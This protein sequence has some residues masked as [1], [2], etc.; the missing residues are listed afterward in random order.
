LAGPARSTEARHRRGDR[1]RQ[2]PPRTS[3]LDPGPIAEG[4]ALSAASQAP[5]YARVTPLTRGARPFRAGNLW[6]KNGRRGPRPGR[7]PG[8]HGGK[9]VAAL[10]TPHVP[11]VHIHQAGLGQSTSGRG[12]FDVF[13]CTQRVSAG[14]KIVRQAARASSFLPP[15]RT[16]GRWPSRGLSADPGRRRTRPAVQ[17][18]RWTSTGDGPDGT[19]DFADRGRLGPSLAGQNPHHR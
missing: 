1:Q 2:R 7:P 5:D 18:F 16:V 6:Q 14:P 11:P 17:G 13:Q 10:Q 3:L 9:F 8:D 4:A 12:H 19:P 15:G